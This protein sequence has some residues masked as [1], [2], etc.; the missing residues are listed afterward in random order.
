[1]LPLPSSRELYVYICIYTHMYMYMHIRHA[2]AI[3]IYSMPMPPGTLTLNLQ[4]HQ[5]GYPDGRLVSPA[6]VAASGAS[7]LNLHQGVDGWLAPHINS[8]LQPL[9]AARLGGYVARAHALGLRA[10]LYYTVR[11]RTHTCT[12][13][14]THTRI[15]CSRSICA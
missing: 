1:M 2:H 6:A 9:A 11:P 7:V 5:V 12:L 15:I 10:K 4:P 13:T 3:S 8:P 14:H